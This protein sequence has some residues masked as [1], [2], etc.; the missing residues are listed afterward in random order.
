MSDFTPSPL[1]DSRIDVNGKGYTRCQF[2]CQ[3]LPIS[4]SRYKVVR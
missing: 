1:P 4:L 3:T 2:R